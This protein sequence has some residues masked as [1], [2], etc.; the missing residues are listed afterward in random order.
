MALAQG[1]AASHHRR[2]TALGQGQT[3][4]LRLDGCQPLKKANVCMMQVLPGRLLT[5]HESCM[6]AHVPEKQAISPSC[7]V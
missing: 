4:G 2:G 7:Q 5:C 6:V 1:L 3:G